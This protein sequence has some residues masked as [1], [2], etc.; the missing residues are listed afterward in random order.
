MIKLDECYKIVQQSSAKGIS[1]VDIAQKLGVY[2]TTVY[3]RLNTLELMNKVESIHGLWYAKTGEQ[4]IKPLEKEIVIELPI[5]EKLVVPLSQL[6]AVANIGDQINLSE[7]A[8][9]YKILLKNLKEARTIRVRGKNVDELDLEKVGKLVS[10]S[11]K[12]SSRFDFKKLF[13]KIIRQKQ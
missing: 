12:K 1:A 3:D 6:E 7:D 10:E 11:T 5:P 13:Q 4:T 2:R 8:N 9:V